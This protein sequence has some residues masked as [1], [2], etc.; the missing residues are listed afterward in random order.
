MDA[1][2]RRGPS[3]TPRLV[4]WM[5]LNSHLPLRDA[6]A[7]DSSFDCQ[8][9]LTLRSDPG[10]CLHTRVLGRALDSVARIALDP[11]LPPTEIIVVG[12]HAP[13]S[14]SLEHRGMYDQ[15]RVPF[16]R[17]IPKAADSHHHA[18][19]LGNQF[20]GRLIPARPLQFRLLFA[21]AAPAHP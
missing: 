11:D 16:I 18:V 3:D 5:T 4:Y 6:D 7:D 1:E 8:K 19:P 20:G 13:P 17:L 2:L 12:D 15:T 14:L 9:F 10:L 21:Q